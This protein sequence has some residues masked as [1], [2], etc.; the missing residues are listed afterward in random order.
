MNEWTEE[1]TCR[2]GLSEDAFA[3]VTRTHPS[4]PSYHDGTPAKFVPLKITKQLCQI[5]SNRPFNPV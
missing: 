1:E 5:A 3:I 4:L 2:F